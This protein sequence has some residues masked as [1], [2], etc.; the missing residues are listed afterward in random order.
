MGV[1]KSVTLVWLQTAVSMANVIA[2]AADLGY[3]AVH[4]ARRN[5]CP[6]R[7]PGMEAAW[8]RGFN[9]VCDY[10]LV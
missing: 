3:D 7:D 8:L 1:T 4:A 10:E 9:Y 5:A 2:Q 6:F